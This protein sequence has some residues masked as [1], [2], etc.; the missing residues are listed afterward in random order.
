M[1]H[2]NGDSASSSEQFLER[3]FPKRL[4]I[5]VE[6]FA[7][8]FDLSIPHAHKLTAGEHPPIRTL[9]FGAAKR[10][11]LDEVRRVLAEGLPRGQEDKPGA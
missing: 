6:E 9:H 11:P 7:N 8:L 5:T 3:L 10:V 2:N 4:A 1:T